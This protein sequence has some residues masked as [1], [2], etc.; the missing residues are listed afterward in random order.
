MPGF[1]F[2]CTC[3]CISIKTQ[4][5]LGF[6]NTFFVQTKKQNST[7]LCHSLVLHTNVDH[8]LRFSFIQEPARPY[9]YALTSYLS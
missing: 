5:I 3:I 1:N 9:L 6:R 2:L 4:N 8:Y 7:S